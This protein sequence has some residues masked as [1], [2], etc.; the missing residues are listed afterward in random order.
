M[1]KLGKWRYTSPTH[2]VRAFY[3]ALDEME[4]EGGITARYARYQENHRRL[5]TGMRSLGF[6]TLGKSQQ[7][8]SLL[9]LP[10][11]TEGKG[12]EPLRGCPQTVFKTAPL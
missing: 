7:T 2:V 9:A 12:F 3:Q 6:Q 4:K 10:V 1:D 11:K 5:V 8:L